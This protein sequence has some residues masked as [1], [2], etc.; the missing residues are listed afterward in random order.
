[1]KKRVTFLVL[2][3]LLGAGLFQLQHGSWLGARLRAPTESALTRAMG[4]PVLVGGVGGGLRGW[5]WLR[6]VAVPALP[7]DAEG[8]SATVRALGLKL[9]LWQVLRGHV[10]LGE[11][12]AI[13]VVVPTIYVIPPLRPVSG[14]TSPH[15]LPH[16]GISSPPVPGGSA[17]HRLLAM[18]P[19]AFSDFLKTLPIPPVPLEVERGAVWSGLPGNA[20]CWV[21]SLYLNLEPQTKGGWRLRGKGQ[22]WDSGEASFSAACGAGFTA[23]HVDAEVRG[24]TWPSWTTPQGWSQPQGRLDGILSANPGLGAWPDGWDLK[25]DGTLQNAAFG[26]SGRPGCSRVKAHWSLRGSRL[27]VSGQGLYSGGA[28]LG[29]GWALLPAGAFGATLTAQGSDLG[30]LAAAA[31]APGNLGLSGPADL[32]L[33]AFGSLAAPELQARL[34]SGSALWKGHP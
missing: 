10:D 14:G 8:L 24:L 12:E 6:D 28:L 15:G 19:S 4:R 22:P 17:F 25:A 5:L 13:Q 1:M 23:P 29:R 20:H 31:G 34:S 7:G 33:V 11:L 9:N 26:P 2:L 21:N 18:D 30:G 32:D 16:G 27:N 3:G